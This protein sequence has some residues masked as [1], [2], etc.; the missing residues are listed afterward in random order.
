[1][2]YPDMYLINQR[3]SRLRLS[4]VRLAVAENL[5]K[6]G[7]LK[8]LAAGDTV[9]IAVGSRGIAGLKEVVSALVECFKR[10]G[11]A[12][13]IVPAMGS[14]G[15]ATAKGQREVLESY[16]IIEEGVGAPVISDMK[17]VEIGQTRDGIQ[18]YLDKAASGAKHIVAVNRIKPHTD[19]RGRIESGLH[20]IMAIGLGKHKGAS[21]YHQAAIQYGLER[22]LYTVGQTVIKNSPLL[23]GVALIENAYEELAKVEILLPPEVESREEALLKEA[24]SLMARLP[25]EEID[26]LVVDQIGKNI[27]GTG[28]DTNV[29]GRIMNIYS[30]EPDS[31]RIKRIIVLGLTPETKGNALGIG[32]ADY[33]TRGVVDQI[34]YQY[35]YTNA[36]TGLVPEKARLPL[37]LDTDAQAVEVAMNTVGLVG[38]ESVRLVRIK[39]TLALE[40]MEISAALLDEARAKGSLE[41]LKGPYPMQFDSAG[42]LLS[43]EI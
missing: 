17:V 7:V 36:I 23:C 8:Q 3:F 16:G 4:D 33:T 26:I 40:K 15:G 18:V 13:F 28:M 6:S 10:A 2:P 1:M 35:T 19:F 41:V 43:L 39:N 9:A 37:V 5:E 25:F 24:S 22:V 29:V 30:E 27:S 21:Y 11:S 20:K 31:P 32:M 42:R 34:N 12:P 38:P 14:H